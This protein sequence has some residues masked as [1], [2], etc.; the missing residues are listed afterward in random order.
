[1]FQK[2]VNRNGIFYNDPKT[3]GYVGYHRHGGFTFHL[4]SRGRALWILEQVGAAI[5]AGAAQ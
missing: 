3:G 2:V 4:M 1:M 5:P